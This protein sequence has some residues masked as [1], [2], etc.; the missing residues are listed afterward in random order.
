MNSSAGGAKA[1]SMI[2]SNNRIS[3]NQGNS[4]QDGAAGYVGT[5]NHD[6]INMYNEPPQ[7]IISLHEFQK[8]SLDRL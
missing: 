7:N 4:M 5:N 6:Q 3:A 8:L 1:S 2:I